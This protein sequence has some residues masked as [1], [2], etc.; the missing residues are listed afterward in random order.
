[1]PL[2]K[3]EKE[4]QQSLLKDEQSVIRNLEKAYKSALDEINTKIAD[5]TLRISK[6]ADDTSAIYQKQ[7]QEML[8]SQVEASIQA[9]HSTNYTEISKYLEDSYKN[10]Y[11]GTFYNMQ[12]QGVPL[13]IPMNQEDMIRAITLNSKI[14]EGLYK[15]LGVD[16]QQMKKRITAEVTRG[17]AS[18]SSWEQIAKQIGMKSGVT[19]S[20]AVRIARTEGHR[21]QQQSSLD[22]MNKAKSKGAD[23]VKQWD[24]TLDGKTRST[25][26]ELD[27]QIVE[28][29][30]KFKSSQGDV[31]APG[32]FGI[33]SEDCNC[34]CCL[35]QRATW[36]LKETIN[37]DTGELVY[38]D[39]D[40]GFSKWDGKNNKYVYIFDADNYNEFKKEFWKKCDEIKKEA[41]KE[42]V[43]L[44]VNNFSNVFLKGSE[45]KQTQKLVDY[46]N[47]LEGAD[48]NVLTLYNSIG[49]IENFELNGIPFKI[50][51]GENHSVSYQYRLMDKKFMDVKLT[52]P[53][54]D[55]ENIAGAVNTTLH[56]NMH[57]I[58]LLLKDNPTKSGTYFTASNSKV[59]DAFNKTSDGIGS[60]ITELFKNHKK[61]YDSINVR[62]RDEYNKNVEDLKTKYLPNGFWGAGSDYKT[63]EKMYKKA[64]KEYES[65]LDYE[66]RNIMGGG[67]GN[68]QDIYDALSGGK[69][70]DIGNVTYG[71]GSKY[72]ASVE[73]RI[74]E[75]IANYGALSVTRP[76]LIEMLR[77]DKPELCKALDESI[78][79]MRKKVE[80][81]VK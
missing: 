66:S 47:S 54:L 73:S 28:L 55:A 31:E 65:K 41:S 12:K 44:D 70:R 40:D 34:R 32:M 8:K 72:Y 48:P 63:Y 6:N 57:L 5:Y 75:T 69:H 52:I 51:H 33:P 53:K 42:V 59:V 77:E 4:V 67:I 71:H 25:H 30:Q 2:N 62:L 49:K 1:M 50:S 10:S 14:S 21:I 29:N 56:E 45:K 20:N 27:G 80:N 26:R 7:Y 17:I 15:R 38:V 16:T 35:L 18:G 39:S 58:D 78:I 37:P 23:I 64:L 60:K 13:A 11:A 74:D 81:I 36:G 19:Y 61:E 79:E 76:D 43:V 46:V 9:L 68:L 3:W 22:A 24:A